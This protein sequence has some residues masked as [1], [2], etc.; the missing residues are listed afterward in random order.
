M[1][2]IIDGYLIGFGSVQ[3]M[4]RLEDYYDEEFTDAGMS[5]F[6]FKD[7]VPSQE[8]CDLMC[9]EFSGEIE[10]QIKVINPH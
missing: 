6:W 4:E 10:R 7:D 3:E 8:E 9:G 1:E 5:E 2:K